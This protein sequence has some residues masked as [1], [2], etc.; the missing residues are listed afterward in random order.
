MSD[1]SNQRKTLISFFAKVNGGQ[2]S[3]ETN[4]LCNID[5]SSSLKSERA[6]FEIVDIPS[7]IDTLYLECDPE[8]CISIKTYPIDK[9]EDAQMTHINM[10]PF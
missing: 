2:S 3:N 7:T 1:K 9:Q 10:G 5:A 4:S 8:L 6:E